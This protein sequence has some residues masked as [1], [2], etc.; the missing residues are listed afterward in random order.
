MSAINPSTLKAPNIL[1]L[2][3]DPNFFILLQTEFFF[4]ADRAPYIFPP[5]STL[6][7]PSIEPLVFVIFFFTSISPFL[8]SIC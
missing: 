6:Y 8:C 4:G 3:F 7:L 2:C 5:I 1:P